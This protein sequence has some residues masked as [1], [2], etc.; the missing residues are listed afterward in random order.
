LLLWVAG[1]AAQPTSAKYYTSVEH[2][3]KADGLSNN[4][5]LCITTDE[6]GLIWIG[7]AYGINRFDGKHFKTYTSR[8]G[9]RN[10]QVHKIIVDGPRLWLL[11]RTAADNG[12]EQYYD[13][14]IF[15][16]YTERTTPFE[17]YY[18]DQLPFDWAR[19]ESFQAHEQT[20]FFKLKNG[21][22]YTFSNAQN[23]D[24]LGQL[25]PNETIIGRDAS[26]FYWSTNQLEHSFS[27]IKRDRQGQILANITPPSAQKLITAR[28]MSETADGNIKFYIY[29]RNHLDTIGVLQISPN[30]PPRLSTFATQ[31]LNRAS[32]YHQTNYIPSLHAMWVT[33]KYQAFLTSITGDT[34]Y[35]SVQNVDQLNT[36]WRSNLIQGHTIWQC[37]SNGLYRIDFKEKSFT[38]T[39][40]SLNYFP[41][42]FRGIDA[43]DTTVYL[44]CHYGLLPFQQ[45]FEPVWSPLTSLPT[46]AV[47]RGRAGR[48][49]TTSFWLLF[50]Y[51]PQDNTFKKY[52]IPCHEPWSIHEDKNGTV[53]VSQV[54]LL[55]V[56]PES[57]AVDTIDYGRFPELANHTVYYFHELDTNRIWLCSTSGLYEMHPDTGIIARYWP[58]GTGPFRLP[59]LDCRHLWHDREEGVFWIATGQNG[60]LRWEPETGESQLFR[61]HSGETNTIHSVYADEHGF[62]WLSTQ[63][64][65]VQFDRN[66]HRFIRYTRK[67]GLSANEFNRISHF[68]DTD[69]RLYFGHVQG[70]TVFH[71]DDFKNAFEESIA[72]SPIVVELQQ[73]LG[74]SNQLENQTAQY[75]TQK[76]VVLHPN[77]RFF[78]V[79]VGID[80]P[81]WADGAAYFYRLKNKDETWTSVED[82]TITLGH[83]PYGQQDIEVRVL[84]PNGRYASQTLTI[85][86]WV[87]RPFYLRWWFFLI[88][89]AVVALLV[90][91]RT[92]Q[93]GQRNKELEAEV[94]R[95]TAKIKED[96][97]LIAQQAAE[98]KQLDDLK[99]RFFANLS[100][101]LRTPLTLIIG[102]LSQLLQQTQSSHDHRLAKMAHGQSQKLLRLVNDIMDLSK[103]ESTALEVNPNPTPLLPFLKQVLSP[104]ELYAEREGIRLNLEYRA[105]KDLAVNMDAQK[106][107]TILHNYLANATKYTTAGGLVQLKAAL[108][109][110]Q[111]RFE[112]KDTGR[113]I[114]AADLPRVFERYFQSSVNTK[115]EGGTGLGLA[116]SKELAKLLGAKVWAESQEGNGSSFFLELSGL[117]VSS[118]FAPSATGAI[119]SLP[120]AAPTAPLQEQKPQQQATVL[121][122][123]DH[124]D[125]QDYLQGLLQPH[126]HTLTAPNGQAALDLLEQS[127]Q[128][129]DLILTDLMMPIMNGYTLMKKLKQQER[130][131]SIPLVVLTAKASLQDRLT[132]LRVGV[133]DYLGKPFVAEELLVRVHNLL[134]NA[135]IRKTAAVPALQTA[136]ADDTEARFNAPE[137]QAWLAKLEETVSKYL[138]D[139]QFSVDF[140]AEKLGLSR[141][142]LNRRMKAKVG[143]TTTQYLQEFRLHHARKLLENGEANSVS[144]AAQAC[145]I[146][147]TKYF[148]RL[149]KKRFGQPPSY[150]L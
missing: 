120:T 122:V 140:L 6:R 36:K 62:L 82:N 139:Q 38:N 108:K 126:Y 39:F 48:L 72:V 67:D 131:Q 22:Y 105:P 104:F 102:P 127:G 78:S 66:S 83:L 17:E 101:E 103:L 98:L 21:T 92:W 68:Q 37:S 112:V 5:V 95:R 93:L 49:W 19:L 81:R 117:P 145:G 28:W 32:L 29:L 144:A 27:F 147:D 7:T 2:F 20:L 23:W 77:D 121:I 41:T 148:S 138:N 60:L 87:K 58:G 150:Y 107:E 134:Q 132:A 1:A 143:L 15:H 44:G 118:S 42:G 90:Y 34:L 31:E 133:D 24:H 146:S 124:H 52:D 99:S 10:N 111:L 137:Q 97:E 56:E 79:T 100:H 26:G 125:M 106:I 89:L 35:A 75:Y 55:S 45:A 14:D 88:M 46:L 50:R 65:I 113:G 16:I 53:W 69:G 109:G 70:V 64:G 135:A 114:P 128:L 86:V 110:Q 33:A 74:S 57:G 123:E 119:H 54:G 13:I 80:D 85:P 12:Q 115:A 149:F 47:K 130:Y 142:T 63:N 141:H 30:A 51:D 59:A 3:S 96:Q 73:Y 25:E 40:A 43:V 76:R 136:A 91:W 61:F 11:Y 4:N 94:Q 71:P 9:L 129:P 8:H 116:L 18:G 84:L